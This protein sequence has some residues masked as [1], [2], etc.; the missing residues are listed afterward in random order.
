MFKKISLLLILCLTTVCI[1]SKPKTKTLEGYSFVNNDPKIL[2]F[3]ATGTETS[4]KYVISDSIK[5]YDEKEK[6]IDKSTIKSYR[7]HQ[8]FIVLNEKDEVIELYILPT[9]YEPG[10]YNGLGVK[11]HPEAAPKTRIVEGY[12]KFFYSDSEIHVIPFDSN[13]VEVYKTYDP[14]YLNENN[15]KTTSLKLTTGSSKIRVTLV[16]INGI[17]YATQIKMLPLQYKTSSKNNSADNNGN[18]DNSNNN[19]GNSSSSSN[20]STAKADNSSNND[21]W[22]EESWDGWSDSG[23]SAERPYT[24]TEGYGYIKSVMPGPKQLTIT[25]KDGKYKNF[26]L[27]DAI[28]D[29]SE[30]AKLYD[31]KGKSISVYGLKSGNY[32]RYLVKTENNEET[33]VE[34]RVLKDDTKFEPEKNIPKDAEKAV[35]GIISKKLKENTMEI[36]FTYNRKLVKFVFDENTVFYDKFERVVPPSDIQLTECDITYVIRDDVYYLLVVKEKNRS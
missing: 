4:V 19:D 31:I 33:I 20:S 3:C 30:K 28:F 11:N 18:S 26:V 21:G 15:L 14:T 29:A 8:F 36:R 13:K 16:T 35:A 32:I 9:K 10:T 25:R 6:L 27:A 12:Y 1:Y 24:I 23:S 5:V 17:E 2:E 34:I 7:T 22:D